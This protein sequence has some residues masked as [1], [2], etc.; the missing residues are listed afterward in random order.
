MS[1]EELQALCNEYDEKVARL[2][3]LHIQQERLKQETREIYQRI[4][5]HLKTQ[6]I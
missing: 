6:A 4:E 1:Q 2:N 5:N 3:I